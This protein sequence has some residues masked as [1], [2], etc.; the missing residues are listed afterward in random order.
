MIL[1]IE[2]EL[3]SG[4]MNP[5]KNGRIATRSTTFMGLAAYRSSCQLGEYVGSGV[6]GAAL[7]ASQLLGITP[8]TLSACR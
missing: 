5:M 7:V 8:A 1:V 3:T 2:K 4:E 6:V